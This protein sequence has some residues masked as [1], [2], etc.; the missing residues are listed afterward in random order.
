M[1]MPGCGLLLALILNILDGYGFNHESINSENIV[2]TYHRTIEAFKY[3]YALRPELGD[4][5]FINNV[6]QVSVILRNVV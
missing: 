3:A 1:P 6:Q 5:N 2:Q 4:M